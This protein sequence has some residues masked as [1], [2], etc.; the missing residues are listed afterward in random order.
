MTSPAWINQIADATLKTDMGLASSTG[1]VSEVAMAQL[2]SD[3]VSEL[4]ANHTSLS[5]S[6][7]ADLKLI[8]S[9]LA[10]GESVS[11]YVAAITNALV[12]GSALNSTW[13]GGAT[14]SSTLG[15]LAIG[16]SA[17]VLNALEGKWFL[18]TDLPSVSHLS[19]VNAASVSYSAVSGSIFGVNGPQMADVN[20]GRIGD[21]YVCSALA[22]VAYQNPQ[23]IESMIT[24]NGN[25]TYG[26]RFYVNGNPQ[27]I[28]VNNQ[29]PNGGGL[30]LN[31]TDLWAS[32]IEKAYAQLQGGGDLTGNSTSYYGNS[33]ATIGNG[34]WPW[35]TLEEITGATQI[36]NLW[37]SGRTSWSE[38]ILSPSLVV[39]SSSSL[40]NA[41]ALN[42]IISSLSNGNDVILSSYTNAYDAQGKQTL[43]SSHALSIYGYDATT[44]M[45]ELRNPWG[46]VS[47]QYWDTTF[48]VSL[49]TLL[50]AN[51]II[52]IDNLPGSANAT[53]VVSGAP[54]LGVSISGASSAITVTDSALNVA[55]N[56]NTLQANPNL[57]TI[58]LTD[59]NPVLTVTSNTLAQ[60]AG[61][62]AKIMGTY[63]LTVTGT[64]AHNLNTAIY[65][66]PL[67]NYSVTLT[68]NGAQVQ[69]LVSDVTPLSNVTITNLQRLQLSDAM[70][71]LDVGPSQNAGSVY[72]LYQAAF[73][74]SPD[75][76]GLGYWINAVDNGANITTTVA[77][78][79]VNSAEFIA[80]Y[81]TNPSNASYV[82]NLYQNVLHRAGDAGGVSYW[83]QQLN[84]GA[85]TKAY[86]LE[87]FATLAEGAANVAPTV[88]H[89]I[90]YTQWV[91]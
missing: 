83:N 9:D 10:I 26:V 27:Y 16:S 12:N 59:S 66:D 65:S 74:R 39:Q 90:A 70:L 17:N 76:G 58:S 19:G 49:S 60:D 25:N 55:A 64:G 82:N 4:N 32:L 44:G 20:Q 79:F 47:G 8:A 13:T 37:G 78:A 48:E 33:Y 53:Q 61:A 21:C 28:T 1:S 63:S 75:M 84:L 51:D 67:V 6:Q 3:L 72:M 68:S 91:G 11:S 54:T 45:L 43:V 31:G 22:E 56:L 5:S 62:L 30:F 38:Q 2:F 23:A 71:A 73:N 77:Q 57:L 14:S 42:L 80:Q 46:T 7:L 81:G 87:Q 50:S 36:I 85:V 35:Y 41:S 86:V 40:N 69:H 52:T 29:L 18:G 34:G 15:N 24:S 89:G 88:A